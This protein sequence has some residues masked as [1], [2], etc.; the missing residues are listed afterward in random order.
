MSLVQPATTTRRSTL[1]RD[2]LDHL[3]PERSTR[4]ILLFF[5]L[6][7]LRAWDRLEPTSN[8][9]AW[10]MTILRHRFYNEYR[11]SQ[12]IVDLGDDPEPALSAIYERVAGCDP[13]GEFFTRIVD[14][15]IW[16]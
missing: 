2:I 13:E 6:L 15:R 10:L 7:C 9:R 5:V 12:H 4:N 16:G 1:N 11:R 8:V 14:A 3:Q